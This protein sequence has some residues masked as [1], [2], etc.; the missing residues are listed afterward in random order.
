MFSHSKGV[1]AL[2]H[3]LRQTFKVALVRPRTPFISS[4]RV[5]FR[6]HK[7]TCNAILGSL[8]SIQIYNFQICQI[9]EGQMI[10]SG[11]LACKLLGRRLSSLLAF[12]ATLVQGRYSQVSPTPLLLGPMLCMH[13][14]W[15]GSHVKL[16]A[17]RSINAAELDK[18]TSMIFL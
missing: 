5:E 14:A 3:L 1:R 2:G 13:M 16:H 10:A 7:L 6:I 12:G 9:C 4:C 17:S 18:G 8:P 15:C 11:I